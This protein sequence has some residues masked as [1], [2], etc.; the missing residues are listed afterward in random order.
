M[1]IIKCMCQVLKHLSHDANQPIRKFRSP[2]E[3]WKSWNNRPSTGVL[4]L[5]FR[6][7]CCRASRSPNAQAPV[8]QAS[9]RLARASGANT[10]NHVLFGFEK[11]LIKNT[12]LV[13]VIH[14]FCRCLV[15]EKTS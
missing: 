1:Q 5:F 2:D 11:V 13:C 4:F 12:R 8:M 10:R 9:F 3:R 7:A 6:R 15:L 14:P